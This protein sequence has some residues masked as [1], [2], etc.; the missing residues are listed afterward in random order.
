LDFNTHSNGFQWDSGKREN[1]A[2]VHVDEDSDDLA[3]SP[4]T[5]SNPEFMPL[6]TFRA[7]QQAS[8]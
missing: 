1:I 5:G 4:A 3:P 2:L 6:N 8:F 7:S